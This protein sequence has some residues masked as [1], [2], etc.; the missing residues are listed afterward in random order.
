MN[1]IK[2]LEELKDISFMVPEYQRG[3]RWQKD[4]VNKLLED[5]EEFFNLLELNNTDEDL[6]YSLQPI[7]VKKENDMYNII[8]GQQRITTLFILFRYFKLSLCKEIIYKT[9]INNANY[10][11]ELNKEQA[12]DNIDF[13]CMYTALKTIEEFFSN[14][15]Q[16]LFKK[17]IEKRIKIIWY[18]VDDEEDELEVFE[19]LNIGKIP[20]NDTE[21]TKA[22]FL[23]KE[24]NNINSSLLYRNAE[25]WYDM[26]INLRNN[27]D[28]LYCLYNNIDKE[29]L[30]KTDNTFIIKDT[31][32]RIEMYLKLFVDS[33]DS[34]RE[35]FE[36]RVKKNK[37]N[38]DWNLLENYKRNLENMGSYE[39]TESLQKDLYHLIGYCISI[40]ISSVKKILEKF[41]QNNSSNDVVNFLYGEIKNSM[42]EVNKKI[43]DLTY[44]EN[45]KDIEKLL[46]LYDNILYAQ[47]RDGN[48]FPYNRF[49]LNQ[50]SIEH[51][52]ARKVNCNEIKDKNKYFNQI[53]EFIQIEIN[54]KSEFKKELNKLLRDIKL[55]RKNNNEESDRELCDTINKVFEDLGIL[56]RFGNLVLLDLKTNKSLNNKTY[57]D[58][59]EWLREN[60]IAIQA[61]IPKNTQNIFYNH[62]QDDVWSHSK[63]NEYTVMVHKAINQFLGE[64][65]D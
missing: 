22:M 4:E 24:L 43:Y 37:L 28:A 15:D 56:D 51:I 59:K 64:N 35:Y 42:K 65:H 10:L 61:F 55:K 20:L 48:G 21:L 41:Q 23:S 1:N 49:K 34:Y 53:E 26:E 17:Y 52:H 40:G 2:R 54:D 31:I 62:I 14:K 63:R 12:N 7:V 38:D 36:Q 27:N 25:T 11:L 32:L 39:Q 58:K 47:E 33:K 29:N 46:L 19:R 16:N 60:G 45:K 5:L 6:Y 3:Y 50:Y 8:D 13:Y 30:Q 9:R 18:E 57:R 44:I